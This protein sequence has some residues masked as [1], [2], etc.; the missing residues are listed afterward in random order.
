MDGKAAGR[1]RVRK[2]DSCPELPL[3]AV[4]RGGELRLRCFQIGAL[5]LVNHYLRRLQWDEVLRRHLPRD[6]PRRQSSRRRE[7]GSRYQLNKRPRKP[8]DGN[9]K[10]SIP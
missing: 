9:S 1:R 4:A 7:F 10:K 6:D 5:P 8:A 3:G 2:Q